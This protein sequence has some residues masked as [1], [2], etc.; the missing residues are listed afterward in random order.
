MEPALLWKMD[1]R[2]MWMNTDGE[3]V[4]FSPNFFVDVVNERLLL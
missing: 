4:K 1:L 2:P 3:G